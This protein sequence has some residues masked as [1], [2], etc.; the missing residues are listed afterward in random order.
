MILGK[1]KYEKFLAAAVSAAVVTSAATPVIQAEASSF[2]DIPQTS[3]YYDAVQSMTLTGAISGYADGTFRPHL[4]VT[5]AQAAKMLASVLKLDVTLEK[6]VSFSDVNKDAW[7][8]GSVSALVNKGIIS[9][10]ADGTFRPNDTITRAQMA[11]M[12]VNAFELTGKESK[13]SFKDVKQGDWFF[14]YVNTLVEN[15]VTVGKSPSEF[16]AGEAVTRGQI[17]IFIHNSN[18]IVKTPEVPADN[19]GVVVPSNPT[20]P[21]A[22]EPPTP[23]ST[24]DFSK[25][26]S[27]AGTYGPASGTQTIN[28]DVVISSPGVTLQ[29]VNITGNLILGAGIGEG[30]VYLN[31]VTVSGTTEVRGG[32]ENS[33]YFNDTVLATVIV[34]KNDGKIRIVAEGSTVVAD[35]QIESYVKVEEKNLDQGAEGFTNVVVAESVQSTNPALAVSLTGTF[36]TVNSRATN[37]RINLTEQTDIQTLIINAL[38]TVLGTGTVS[39]AE[40]NA[41]G[42]SLE[43]RPS[44]LVLTIPPGESIQIGTGDQVQTVTE[45]YSDIETTVLTGASATQGIIDVKMDSFVADLNESDFTVSAKLIGK[46]G[47]EESVELQNLSYN[48]NQQRFTYEPVALEGNADKTL[49]ITV[50]PASEK[51]SGEARTVEVKLGTGFEGRITDIYGVGVAGLKIKFR[52]GSGTTAGEVAGEA[53]TDKYG[54]YSVSLPAGIYTGELSGQGY[55]TSYMLGTAETNR[56]VV[57][58]NETAIRAAA[59]NEVKVM[60]SWGENPSDLDSHLYGY[61]PDGKGMFHTWFA[62][63]IHSENGERIVDLDWDDVDSFGPETTT[64]RKLKD[65]KYKFIVHNFSGETPLSTSGGKVEFFKGNSTTPDYTFSVPEGDG[66]ERYWIVFEMTVTNNGEN[67]DVE[68]INTLTNEELEF[69]AGPEAQEVMIDSD[70]LEEGTLEAGDTID[71]KFNTVLE[72]SNGEAVEAVRNALAGTE[73]DGKVEVSSVAGENLDT[74][75]IRLKVVEGQSVNLSMVGEI[76]LPEGVVTDTDGVK[77]LSDIYFGLY[78]NGDPGYPGNEYLEYNIDSITNNGLYLPLNTE[79]VEAFATISNGDSVLQEDTGDGSGDYTYETQGPDFGIIHLK[80]GYMD[81]LNLQAGDL[82]DFTLSSESGEQLKVVTVEAVDYPT[83]THNFNF[84]D[85]EGN[86]GVVAVYLSEALGSSVGVE[87]EN[88]ADVSASVSVEKDSEIITGTTSVYLQDFDGD[89]SNGKRPAIVISGPEGALIERPLS[90]I[91]DNTLFDLDGNSFGPNHG[92]YI[93]NM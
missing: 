59:T 73:F 63:E 10:Y 89:S 52:A 41:A 25:P 23:P 19:G 91:I 26:I 54:Y 62:D 37:V 75:I 12:L 82:V 24:V 29:N 7:F 67:I 40:I 55:M 83:F 65:G 47:T 11:K 31:G 3:A 77:N 69:Y 34:N 84:V 18:K 74:D 13:N 70:T 87:L 8:A 21:P 20:P 42:T 68:A 51:V 58:Q 5:R 57:E 50:A 38:A 17:A 14:Q 90:V 88:N 4:N 15:K 36:D 48:S 39:T 44:N 6:H 28:G 27:E 49:Q 86:P 2:S 60:L 64:I 76:Y 32:G 81:S 78:G 93:P 43:T 46:D 35:L 33:I 16:G 53:T 45:S 22:T 9:G 1:K 61:T 92:F 30:E 66:T 85:P 79:E 71:L 80:K 56:Y 72:N